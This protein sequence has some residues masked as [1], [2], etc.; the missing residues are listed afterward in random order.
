[1]PDLTSER[2]RTLLRYDALTGA[3][4]WAQDRTNRCKAGQPA[5]W[6][7]KGGYLHIRVDGKLYL[8]HRLAW[9]YVYGKW[10][11]SILDHRNRFPSDNRISNLRLATHSQNHGN[12]PPRADN[13]SGVK[14]VSWCKRRSK[15]QAG[16]RR[17]G[18][19]VGLGYFTNIEDAAK[20]YR[21]A[22]I[23]IYGD[24]HAEYG[25]RS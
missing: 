21:A 11:T 25:A 14:G 24:F 20:A 22:S 9:L 17:N 13:T 10:P 4:T 15:W 18:K 2:L 19:R 5:G 6:S 1:M 8:A 16:I 12:T 3:F 23:E 7:D